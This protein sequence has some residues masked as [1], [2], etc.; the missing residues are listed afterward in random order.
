VD[1]EES[2][3]GML[4]TTLN[5]G[6]YH[7][8]LT[9]SSCAEALRIIGD[10]PVD[11]LLTDMQMPGGSG[12]KLLAEVHASSPRMATLMITARD[13]MA[14]AEQ[15]LAVGAYGY[16][17]K[18]FRHNEILIGV[19]NAL[20]RRAL[21]LENEGHREHLEQQVKMRGADLWAALQELAT[22]ESEV[23]S[24]R[25]ET[26]ARLAIAAELRD[27]ETG[28]HVIR[29]SRS[30]EV[31]ARAAGMDAELQEDMRVAASL[32][33]IGKIGIPDSILLKP[34]AH[35]PEERLV[36]QQHAQIGHRILAGSDAPILKLAAEIA[37][38]HHE[39][40]D[41]TGY[42]NGLVGDS[43]PLPGRIAAIAD[44][45]DAL[46]TNRVYRPAFGLVEA[47]AMMKSDSGTHFDPKLLDTFFDI[48][49]EILDISEASRATPS[50]S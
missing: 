8:V 12:L 46:T 14:L 28:Q 19:S 15:A 2:F 4:Q 11:L 16:F 25:A 24:S 44:V 9:A 40:V 33:D 26:T 48:L 43:I 6:G 21:E 47:V 5:R 22:S 32:H 31:L 7:D 27:E 36:M 39:K 38:T 35:S 3:V 20:R 42:P 30:C 50:V 34:G 10:N 29:M 49:P 41:G 17:I 23:R 37:L 18:P 45:F 13:E 1:D